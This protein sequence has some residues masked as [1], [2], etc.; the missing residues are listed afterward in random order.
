MDIHEIQRLHA[1]FAPDSMVI[2]LPRQ[3]AALPAPGDLSAD[4][5]PTA[6]ARWVQ[7]GPLVR[8]SVIAVGVAVLIGMAGMGA[9]SLYKTRRGADTSAQPAPAIPSTTMQQKSPARGEPPAPGGREIDAT[10][11]RPVAAAPALSASDFGTASS[12][13]LTADQFRASMRAAAVLDTPKAP[14]ALSSEVQLAAASPIRRA[15]T[16]RGEA[17][18]AAAAAVAPPQPVAPANAQPATKQVAPAGQPTAQSATPPNATPAAAVQSASVQTQVSAS[19]SAASDA[20]RSARTVRQPISR[21]RTE[22][23]ADA[24]AGKL[25]PTRRAGSTEVQMF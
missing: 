7:A 10:P 14:A 15:P 8:R 17:Q 19:T 4:D 24:D 11:A 16:S 1:Q 23:A 20:P 6:R 5:A 13:G 12:L 22:Q 9:A 25:A 3:L 2:D 21:P 18:Q